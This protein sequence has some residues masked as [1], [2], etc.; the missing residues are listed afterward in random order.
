MDMHA[1]P[2]LI[3][4]RAFLFLFPLLKL[5][6]L[7]SH[8]YRGKLFVRASDFFVMT[9]E[10]VPGKP[11][12][13]W[14][15]SGD[16]YPVLGSWFSSLC[17]GMLLYA[18]AEV[19]RSL[20]FF[21]NVNFLFRNCV[22]GKF[23]QVHS[24]LSPGRPSPIWKITSG[25][26]TTRQ[27]TPPPNH[28]TSHC[29]YLYYRYITWLFFGETLVVNMKTHA[30]FIRPASRIGRSLIDQQEYR[31]AAVQACPSMLALLL[32]STR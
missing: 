28:E 26:P 22:S 27:P 25:P 7:L 19:I 1:T 12:G 3:L 6:L 4:S 15:K 5:K 17:P 16:L 24:L 29:Q 14:L 9:P 20:Y 8:C 2:A 21:P 10:I 18:V 13:I 30:C 31:V 23:R 32:F 11:A